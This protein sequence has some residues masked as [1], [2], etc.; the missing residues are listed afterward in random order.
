MQLRLNLEMGRFIL[1]HLDGP[2]Y[3]LSPWKQNVFSVWS[4]KEADA[5]EAGEI[6]NLGA[7]QPTV[8]SENNGNQ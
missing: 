5:E 1:N 4:Q 3:S 6:W 8:E 7:I 2:I